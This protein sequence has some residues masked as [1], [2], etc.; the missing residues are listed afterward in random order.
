VDAADFVARTRFR[1]FDEMSDLRHWPRA[2]R[3]LRRFDL[4]LEIANTRLPERPRS[5]RRRLEPLLSMPRMSSYALGAAINAGVAAMPT[6]TVYLNVG[7]WHGFS[8]FCGLAG[9]ESRV[10]IGVDDFS[11][12]G[13]PREE[14]LTRYERRRTPLAEFYDMDFEDYLRHEHD[15]RPIG[16]YFYDAVHSYGSQL[17]ALELAEPFFVPGTVVL[18]DDTNWKPT[19]RATLDFY[20]P[21]SSAYELAA[22]RVTAANHHPTFWNGVIL[23]RRR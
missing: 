18:V 1:C 7:V 3:L 2:E 12:W 17:A 15:G 19:R 23:L 9:N 6:G 11:R 14:F 5:T 8:F 4:S 13:S 21:R 22:Y 20:E 16:F 10:C